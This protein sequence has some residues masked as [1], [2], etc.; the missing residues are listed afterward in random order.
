MPRALCAAHG[1]QQPVMCRPKRRRG[2]AARSSVLGSSGAAVRT[3]VDAVKRQ[4][5]ASAASGPRRTSPSPSCPRS[6]PPL[7]IAHS[8]PMLIIVFV[9]ITVDLSSI[10]GYGPLRLGASD[11]ANVDGEWVPVEPLMRVRVDVIATEI[12]LA[13]PVPG[14]SGLTAV[15]AVRLTIVRADIYM[16]YVLWDFSR[17]G[18]GFN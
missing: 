10:P 15:F 1:M 11:Y 8:I 17:D 6:F 16:F 13:Q 5:R 2:R 14:L 3:S 7:T 4:R 9:L 12:P 18:R